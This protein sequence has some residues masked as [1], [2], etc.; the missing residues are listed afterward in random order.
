[1]DRYLNGLFLSDASQGVLFDDFVFRLLVAFLVGQLIGWAYRSAHLGLS[2]SQGFVQSL[3]L[4]AMVTCVVMTIVGDS[5]ARA[6]GLGAALAIV[7][8][9]TP[10]K[11]A[12]DTVFL[13]LSMATGMAAGAGQAAVAAVS[14]IAVSAVALHLKRV[15]FGARNDKEGLLRLRLGGTPDDRRL[16]DEVLT[17]HCAE[18]Q[19]TAVRVLDGAQDLAFELGLRDHDGADALIRDL[20]SL[21]TV[22]GVTLLAHARAGDGQ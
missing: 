4:L 17:R 13:F 20:R 7:R 5:L 15:S 19:L 2:Y 18:V 16:L 22:S 12:R 21:T 14:G 11:D 1:M 10:V 9:R 3:V 8:F 6:F